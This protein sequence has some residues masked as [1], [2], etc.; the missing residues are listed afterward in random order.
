MKFSVEIVT[1]GV[2]YGRFR[3]AYNSE[4]FNREVA[5]AAK[6]KERTLLEH[7]KE[8]DGKERKRIRIVPNVSLPAAVQ[9]LFPNGQFSYDEVTVLDPQA[10]TATYAIETPI[11]DKIQVT[12]HAKYLEEGGGVRLLFEGEANVKIFGVGSLVERYLVSEVT[13]RYALVQGLLQG[14]IDQGRDATLTP[15]LP[16]PR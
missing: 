16:V 1:R 6:L 5:Q 11:G 10:R 9:K 15:S 8:P 12:G 13:A 14:F 3:R 4:Q 2:D 7:V